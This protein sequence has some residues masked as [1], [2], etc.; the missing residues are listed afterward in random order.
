[1][2]GEESGWT[3]N[4]KP[5]HCE[6]LYYQEVRY[7]LVQMGIKDALDKAKATRSFDRSIQATAV[8][9]YDALKKSTDVLKGEDSNKFEDFKKLAK[10]ITAKT[11]QPDM[12]GHFEN[13]YIVLQK[14][15][16]DNAWSNYSLLLRCHKFKDNAGRGSI[17]NKIKCSYTREST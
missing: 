6:E 4:R 14:F 8:K 7:S 16:D 15:G 11:F 1:M 10:G 3:G 9:E 12:I 13:L 5:R 17:D 2:K